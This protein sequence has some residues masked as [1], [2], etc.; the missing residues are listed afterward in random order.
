M[1]QLKNKYNIKYNKKNIN[2]KNKKEYNQQLIIVS[3]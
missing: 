3:Q 2:N 1:Y